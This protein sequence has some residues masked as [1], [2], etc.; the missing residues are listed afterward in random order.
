MDGARIIPL[1]EFEAELGSLDAD[2]LAAFVGA[3]WR[4][5]GASVRVDPPVVTVDGTAGTRR[6]A[7]VTGSERP[8]HSDVDAV[9]WAGSGSAE[10]T[11]SVEGIGPAELHERLRYGLAPAR[12]DALCEEFLGVPA[13]SV[14]SD[15]WGRPGSNETGSSRDG[16]EP[17]GE[18]TRPADAGSDETTGTGAAG[19][20]ESSG[21]VPP[22]EDTD[23]GQTSSVNIGR[24]R[25]VALLVLA[26]VV[27]AAIGTVAFGLPGRTGESDPGPGATAPSGSA[28]RDNGTTAPTPTDKPTAS[29]DVQPDGSMTDGGE[30]E[31][32]RNIALAPTCE[33]SYLQVVQI[34][35]N[36]LRYN[37]NGTNDG[38]RTVRRFASP[39]N[40]E[41][42][43]SFEGF[44]SVVRSESYESLLTHDSAQYTPE[45]I[46]P[47]T[48][49]V[50]VHTRENGTVTGRYDF[51]MVKVDEDR[52]EGCWMTAGV[53]VLPDPG[54]SESSRES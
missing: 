32:L 9:V 35:V 39:R 28:P 5:M 26:V 21:D 37:D 1:A 12:A 11:A 29:V 24:P 13:W 40:R 25:S 36:A 7:V 49:R 4:E 15:S 33:R 45:Q 47:M 54:D 46:G 2:A 43:S 50:K 53:Q 44:V 51:R 20:A 48:A 18:A 16:T 14:P 6:L 22:V 41:L 3:L 42:F 27:L 10:E 17:N 34:Q 8:D 19:V 38:I 52:Y 23:G 30:S 31:R